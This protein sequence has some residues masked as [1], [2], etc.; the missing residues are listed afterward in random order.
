MSLPRFLSRVVDAAV[1]ALGGLDRGAVEAKLGGTSVGLATSAVDDAGRAGFLLAANLLARLYPR[2]VV[3][4]PDDVAAAAAGEITLVNPLADVM[5][6]KATMD[7]AATAKLYYDHAGPWTV[8]DSTVAVFARRWN[9]YV[10]EAP[11]EDGPAAPAAAL[12]AAVIGVAEL[13]RIVF[14]DYLGERGRRGRQPG[15]FN[16]ITLGD[17]DELVVPEV[18]DVGEV[19][20]V[21]AGAIGQAAALALAASRARGTLLAVDDEPVELSNLQRYVLTRDSDVGALKV[22]LLRE[23]LAQS[24]LEVVPLKTEWYAGLVEAQLKTLVALDSPEARMGVQA[25][26]PGP[27][28]N[29]WTQPADVGWS[30]HE[31]FGDEP[32]LACLYWP[33]GERPSR[34]EQI[35]AAFRQHPLRVLAYLVLGQP[36]GL[37]LPPGGVP[38]LP[39]LPAPPESADWAARPL[40]E[41]LAVAAGVEVAELAAWRDR[42]LADVYQDGICGGGLLHL[43]VGVAPRDVL[44]P[45]GHQSAFAG[46][47]LAVELIAASVPELEVRRPRAVEGRFD[48]LSGL[49]QMLPRPRARTE[50][51]FCGDRVWREVYRGKFGD[52][53]GEAA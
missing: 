20:L 31:H 14:A 30:R 17:P 11:D 45:L 38:S 24:E 47:M 40:V 16:L 5:T 22:D 28:Y 6:E 15:A 12:L 27:I 10:D 48:V 53:A 37:P 18:V 26:L 25:S 51:C 8:D 13:F 33:E 2:V 23:R 4:A 7:D 52:E 1:P 42:T 50:R 43:D 49:P 35:A 19:R 46:V 21:G 9:V 39:D 44:V 36:V 3:V 32:C 29:A 41:D 34:H